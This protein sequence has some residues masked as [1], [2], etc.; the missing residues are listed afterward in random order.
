[1]RV[2]CLVTFLIVNGTAS[3]Q[4]AG[5][6]QPII[7]MHLHAY[8]LEPGDPAWPYKRM[9]VNNAKPCANGPSSYGAMSDY[10]LQ[11]TV[12]MMKK[13]NVV[14]GFLS[15]DLAE[16]AR[17]DAAAPG[18]FLPSAGV[19]D[20]LQVSVDSIRA[21]LAQGRVKGIGEIGAQYDGIPANDARLEPYFALAESLDAPVLIHTAGFGSREPAFR[22]YN[23]R[24]LLLEE[25][26]VRHPRLRIYVENAGYPFLDDI[27]ALML[28]YPHVYVDVSTITW[29]I[30][31]AAFHAYL[32]A[33]I[34][35]GFAKRIMFGSDQLYWPEVIG[36][37]V[38]AI[39]SAK[40]L[41]AAQRQD[42][43]YNN[44]ARFLRLQPSAKRP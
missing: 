25:V 28:Q 26:L 33:L 18:R 39:E 27:V 3:A 38:G 23:G 2:L 30:P 19:Y 13:Y 21:A 14:L 5:R 6:R 17:W 11:G 44:A 8:L 7:D 10:L 42:I 32:E 29:L 36:E 15:G 31:R 12:V 9:C 40:F 41:S 34:R 20:G 22:A 16:V 1:M 4:M 37:A 35:A 43:F 24:P